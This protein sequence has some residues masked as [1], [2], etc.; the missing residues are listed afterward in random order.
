MCFQQ[1]HRLYLAIHQMLVTSTIILN[2]SPFLTLHRC[3]PTRKDK[4][5]ILPFAHIP[6]FPSASH[7]HPS[8]GHQYRPGGTMAPLPVSNGSFQWQPELMFKKADL[9]ISLPSF[10]DPVV[11]SPCHCDSP[12]ILAWTTRLSLTWPL[13]LASEHSPAPTV[14]QT[15]RPFCSSDG[16]VGSPL[17]DLNLTLLSSSGLLCLLQALS[18]GGPLE[19]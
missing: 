5:L 19:A 6:M 11:A 3:S 15:H 7:L 16:P 18:Q 12:N 2:S 10:K 17:P 4:K 14:L 9:S 1:V 13:L 8:Q